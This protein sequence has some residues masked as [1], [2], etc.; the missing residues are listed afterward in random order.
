MNVPRAGVKKLAADWTYY[1]VV[2]IGYPGPVLDGHPINDPYNLGHGW[3]GLDFEKAFG[4][5]VKI[6]SDAAMQA[7]GSYSAGAG[8]RVL[9]VRL[10][11]ALPLP[12]FVS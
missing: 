12:L 1:E 5:P 7:L 6:I 11:W 8:S 2:S 10:E 3:V 4:C 9:Q